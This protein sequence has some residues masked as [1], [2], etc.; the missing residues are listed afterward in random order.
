MWKKHVRKIH[1]GDDIWRYVVDSQRDYEP[2]EVRI[3]DPKKKMYRITHLDLETAPR[4][5]PSHIKNYIID[6]I[7]NNG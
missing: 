6:K 7:L 4:I 5:Q 2:Q 1:I 3:Y